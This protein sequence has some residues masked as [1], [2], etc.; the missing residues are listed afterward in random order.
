[1][2]YSSCEYSCCARG[3]RG[4]RGFPGCKG[5]DGPTGPQGI[6]GVTGPSQGPTGLQGSTGIMG[7]TGQV[8]PT[9]AS[10]TG[11]TGSQGQVGPTGPSQG[12]TGLQ[13]PTGSAGVFTEG[14][15]ATLEKVCL[16]K[17][18]CDVALESYEL[19]SDT[20]FNNGGLF[21]LVTGIATIAETGVY[22]VSAQVSFK[23]YNNCEDRQNSFSI[24]RTVGETTTK[25]LEDNTTYTKTD[26]DFVTY[27]ISGS[28]RL[29]AGDEVQLF[30]KSP[31]PGKC[32]SDRRVICGGT[33]N[34]ISFW[35]STRKF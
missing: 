4:Y 33:S 12:P 35:S 28:V 24:R 32:C 15:F 21:D 26:N 1:M 25:V 30:F 3:P 11:P 19:P 22:D 34:P 14:F 16:S 6:Q 17:C 8:G 10:F 23:W 9:G 13:G 27:S 31:Y 2:T 18:D 20:G 29:V 7:S 5:K